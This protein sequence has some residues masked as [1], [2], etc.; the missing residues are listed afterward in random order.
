[1]REGRTIRRTYDWPEMR[2]TIHLK[3]KEKFD[4]DIFREIDR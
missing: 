4:L 2:L 3:V 1:M